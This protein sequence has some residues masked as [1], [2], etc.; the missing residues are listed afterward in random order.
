MPLPN[1]FANLTTAQMVALDQN[2]AALG[3][4]GII[5]CTVAGSDALVLTP[6]ANTPT[7]PAYANYQQFSGIVTTNNT[8]AGTARIGSLAILPIYKDS[9]S[10]PIALTGGELVQNN[11]FTLQY[12]SALNSGGGGF[13]LASSTDSDNYLPLSG[14]TISG[15]LTIVGVSTATVQ[16][17][18]ISSLATLNATKLLVGA[19][20][21]SV[22]RIL[23]SLASVGF[24]VLLANTTQDQ[25]ILVPGTLANDS[26]SIGGPA[27]ITA[28]VG[29]TGYVAAAGTVN[30]RAMNVTAASIAAFSVTVRATAIGF[31]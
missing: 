28:G 19:S 10:G 12:D 25:P 8:T 21:A 1:T 3:A 7:V 30:L 29:F 14:G 17:G 18:S 24:T 4:L 6:N 27:S 23:S 5:P 9:P 26:I 31:T 16:L 20:A 22:T 11:M 2:D 15:N 13:H